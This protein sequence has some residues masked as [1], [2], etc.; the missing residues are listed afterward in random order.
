MLSGRHGKHGGRGGWSNDS[1]NKVCVEE[2][3]GAGTLSKAPSTRMMAQVYMLYGCKTWAMTAELESKMERTE[4]RMIRWMCCV[5][6]RERQPSTELRRRLG[7]EA[8]AD[9]M[10]RFRLGWHGHVERKDDADYVKT[11][12]KLMEE[13]KT[14]QNTLSADV[15]VSLKERQPSIEIIRRLG[16]EAIGHVRRRCRL[17]WHGHVER[18]DD[19][20][21][22]KA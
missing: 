7:V 15:C 9:V 20:D 12:A 17:G 16:V 13:G 5:S 18:K 11:S 6:L 21:Y 14:R 3:R 10:R 19:A 22:V 2:I 1:N 8:T 4:M